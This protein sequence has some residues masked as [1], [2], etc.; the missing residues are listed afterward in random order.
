VLGS[1]KYKLDLQGN[2]LYNINQEMNK[3]Y[4]STGT[5][6]KY[7]YPDGTAGLTKVE[8]TY[9]DFWGYM[10]KGNFSWI[11]VEGFKFIEEASYRGDFENDQNYFVYSKTA[12]ES[13]INSM[14]SMGVSY[15]VDYTNL[16]PKGN[17]RTD[18]TTMVSLIIDY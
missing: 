5:E 18:T 11:I 14:F 8:G 1:K 16:P 7:P 2:V 9:N 12:L 17:E 15:K 6:V 3:Y 10:L 13:K 4:D